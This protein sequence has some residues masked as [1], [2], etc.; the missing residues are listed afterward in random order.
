MYAIHVMI[1]GKLYTFFRGVLK[2][3]K[4]EEIDHVKAKKASFY[5]FKG[6]YLIPVSLFG[7]FII[8]DKEYTPKW[9]G[10]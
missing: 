1:D 7:W 10:G 9:L 4:S 5:V 3:K 8:K 6:L 2:E